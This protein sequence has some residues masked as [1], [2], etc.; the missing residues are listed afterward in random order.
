[1]VKLFLAEDEIIMRNGIKKID[2]IS[3][4]IELVGEA[5]DGELAYPMILELKPDILLT[6]IKM[7]FMDGLELIQ[8]VKQELPDLQVIILSG[9]DEFTYAQRA[10]SLGVTEYLL[11]PVTPGRLLECVRGV[12]QKIQDRRQRELLSDSETP[13]SHERRELQKQKLF[14]HLVMNTKSSAECLDM[15][16]QV[17]VNLTA[18]YFAVILLMIRIRG[19]AAGDFSEARNTLQDRLNSLLEE[20]KGWTLFD[21]GE[22]GFAMLTARN[23][24]DT[25]ETGLALTLERICELFQSTENLEY[26]IS[27][28]PVAGRVSE[29]RHSYE[30]AAKAA[31]YRFLAGPNQVVYAK[32]LPGTGFPS[33]DAPID[34]NDAVT[35]SDFR[36]VMMNFMHTGEREEIAPLVEEMFAAIGEKNLNS[37]IFMT[38]ILMDLY[39][40]MVRFARENEISCEDIDGQL[41]NPRDV[42]KKDFSPAGAARYIEE[43]LDHI[44]EKRDSK[45]EGRISLAL[46]EAVAY[47]DAS[48]ACEDISLAKAAA[49]ANI[50]PNHFSA[51]F[52]QQMG[53]TFM[54]YLIGKRMEKA[55]KLL[56]TTDMRSSEIA[57]QVGYK[58]PHYFS[59]TFKKN[60]GMTPME[61]RT[62]GGKREQ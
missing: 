17:Q 3:S 42:L 44:L 41:G 8:R 22:N 6:D 4:D 51:V 28:G 14:R 39:L 58:D 43:Y 23:H 16:K 55:K 1:M 29:I 18:R 24:Q 32:D 53:T 20:Q 37:T 31:A 61:Y 52:S 60:Q 45:K 38:Y 62:S 25:M 27:V 9:F 59:H 13:V 47:I 40:A 2:W 5:S 50:S 12:K 19:E 34:L 21:R 15:A 48:Y 46:R 7:P 35:N 49:I 57:F 11:K 26:F 33:N 30:Q 10:V 36:D 56:L 54:E